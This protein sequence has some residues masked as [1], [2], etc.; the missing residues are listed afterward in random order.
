MQIK[1]LYFLLLLICFIFQKGMSGPVS[2]GPWDPFWRGQPVIGEWLAGGQGFEAV[3]DSL[4][5]NSFAVQL[6]DAESEIAFA[7]DLN[8]VRLIGG[9][10]EGSGTEK[11]VPADVA[12]LVYRDESGELQYRWDKLALRLDPYISR[13]YTNLTLVLD[14][15]PY[16]FPSNLVMESYGQVATPADFQEWG[17]FVSNLCAQLVELYGFETANNFRFRQG[18]EAQSSSRFAGTQE[19]YFKIYDY[20]AA[21]LKSVLPGAKFGPFNAA[22]GIST[23]HNVRIEELARHCVSGTNYAT[24][25]VGSPLDFIAV[26]S[27]LAQTNAA[28][29]SARSRADA[30]IN[31]FTTVQAELPQT[32]PWEMHEFGILTCESGLPTDEPGARGAA[33]RFHVVAQLR[34]HGLSRWYHWGIFDS[35][36]SRTRGLLKIMHSEGW[37][38]SVLD[39]TAGG[40]GFILNTSAPENV[41][42]EIKAIG[43]FG[44][45]RDWILVSA[46]NPDRLA[47]D[48]ETVEIFIPQNLLRSVRGDKILWTSLNQTNAAHYLIRKDLEEAGLLNAAFAAVPEQLASV[49]NMTTNATASAE[50]DFLGERI[51]RYEQAVIDSLTLKTFP[52]TVATNDSDVIFTV[53][54]TPPETAV[55]C[56]GPDRTPSGIPY[57]WLDSYGL[58]VRGYGH[59]A[60]TDWDGDGFTAAQEYVLG[61][62][63]L[64]GKTAPPRIDSVTSNGDDVTV[65]FTAIA[66]RTYS[67]FSRTNLLYGEWSLL[68]AT[69]SSS[70]GV[71]SIADTSRHPSAFYR[72]KVGLP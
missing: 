51:E 6:K 46:Y 61:A 45:D 65:L 31:V 35:F 21:A 37:L 26:S 27:Y 40:E 7:D 3:P 12:D 62:D 71:Y 55:I 15:I 43:V 24:G 47:H 64:D 39:R 20:S 28:R 9:W 67:L 25:T 13:G 18:T 48:P 2:L 42:T 1:P 44:G 59:G 69:L 54:L 66:D 53:I 34:E 56:I 33:W 19:D 29:R 49:R 16:C 60:A 70:G 50:Q 17:T 10:N 57:A 11:P 72:L 32:I 38:L 23:N 30:S 5:R 58:G 8:V 36:R 41:G 68:D 4:K 22:G 14:N 52:G 63:P